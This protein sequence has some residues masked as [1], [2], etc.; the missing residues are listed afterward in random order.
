MC[1][2]PRMNHHGHDED[3]L[4]KA[5]EKVARA[6]ALGL[7]AVARSIGELKPKPDSKPKVHFDFEVGPA[8]LKERRQMPLAI[9]ISNEQKVTV[10]VTPKTNAGKPAKLDGAPTWTVVSGDSTV[11]P[12]TDGLSAS[13]VS[14][15]NPGDT[16][17]LVEADADLGE[18]VETI[19]DTITLT[20][21][22]ANAANLGL[23][24]GQPELK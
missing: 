20:V 9:S 13:L 2:L 18:G 21:I 7:E 14:A 10:T 19:Q 5:V 16:T 24:A 23:S 12:A 15:D 17:Y 6:I 22:G 1:Y 4:A 3:D 8:T 11:V